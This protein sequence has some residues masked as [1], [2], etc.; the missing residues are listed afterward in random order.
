MKTR[1]N[2]L[3]A[4]LALAALFSLPLVVPV[5]AQTDPAVEVGTVEVE[6]DAVTAPAPAPTDSGVQPAVD[7]TSPGD[8]ILKA[9]KQGQETYR[10]FSGGHWRLALASLITMLIFLWRRFASRL[11]VGK[12]GEWGMAF[13]TALVAFLATI[14]EALAMEPFTWTAFLMSGIATTGEAMAVWHLAGKK[15]LPKLFG[16]HKKAAASGG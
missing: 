8:S 9:V 12:L 2:N 14:P 7:L 16:A 10:L 5:Q 6:T 1:S 4:M 15:M 3:C 11:L 13:T